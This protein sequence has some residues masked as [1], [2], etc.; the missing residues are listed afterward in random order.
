MQCH[1]QESDIYAVNSLSFHPYG[2]FATAGSDGVYTFWDKDA[3]QRLKLFN[4]SPNS[5]TAS[6][7]NREGSIYAYALGYDWSK[8]VEYYQRQKEPCT[9]MLKA[10]QE[11]E[12]AKKPPAKK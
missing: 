3:K 1:R 2:T 4:R 6:C 10:V 5:I 8:G 11:A 12:I 7:F 9:L